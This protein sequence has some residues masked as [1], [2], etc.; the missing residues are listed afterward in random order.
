LHDICDSI[1]A[2]DAPNNEEAKMEN[3]VS[4]FI[5][6]GDAIAEHPQAW[7][8]TRELFT[9]AGSLSE[10]GGRH[11]FKSRQ[12]AHYHAMRFCRSASV[13]VEAFVLRLNNG[14]RSPYYKELPEW[15]KSKKKVGHANLF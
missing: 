10:A 14:H 12:A 5:A 3:P 9:G 6:L 2:F 7:K 11:G 15:L 8:V 13:A 4:L 1:P